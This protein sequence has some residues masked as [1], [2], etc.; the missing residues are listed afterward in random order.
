[1]KEIPKSKC[2]GCDHFIKNGCNAPGKCIRKKA[3]DSLEGLKN[4]EYLI[5]KIGK[6]YYKIIDIEQ[7]IVATRFYLKSFPTQNELEKFL[8]GYR[9][10]I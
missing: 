3:E 1:M 8:R 5:E 4:K 7:D 9:F 2:E 10:K 6:G